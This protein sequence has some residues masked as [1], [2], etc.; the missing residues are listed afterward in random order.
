MA[1]C[2]LALG[3]GVGCAPPA[4]AIGPAGPG[5]REGD[6]CDKARCGDGFACHYERSGERTIGVCRVDVGRCRDD[7]DCGPARA[8]QRLGAGLGVCVDRG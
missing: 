5:S 7:R 8:C 1:R 6:A 2:L 3:A 4:A